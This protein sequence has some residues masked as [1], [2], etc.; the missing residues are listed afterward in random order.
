MTHE[1]LNINITREW[2]RQQ[3]RAEP[4]SGIT[5]VGGLAHRASALDALEVPPQ[6]P[7]PSLQLAPADSRRHSLGKFVELSR[8]RM[9]LSVE[10]LAEKANI[11]LVELLAIENAEVVSPGPRTIFQLAQ[12]LKVSPEPLMEL[13]GLVVA[14]S[15]RLAESA[16]RFAARSEPMQALSRDEEKALSWFVKELTKP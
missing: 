5:S 9:R 3:A 1:K 16:L 4:D 13:A 12:V 7:Q 2:A 14:R 15:E 8:R 6:Q 11:D 10:Q